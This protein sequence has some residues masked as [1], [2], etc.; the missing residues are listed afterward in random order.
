ME[1]TTNLPKESR[2]YKIMWGIQQK[3]TYN[4]HV[5][6]DLELKTNKPNNNKVKHKQELKQPILS[7]KTTL[8]W[9]KN[10]SNV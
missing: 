4:G 6:Q 5:W 2:M 1:T 3:A 9:T 8:F 10:A 7:V